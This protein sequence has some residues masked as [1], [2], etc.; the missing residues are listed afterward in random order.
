[1][2]SDLKSDLVMTPFQRRPTVHLMGNPAVSFLYK[3][4]LLFPF[5]C[6]EEVFVS[7]GGC[8]VRMVRPFTMLATEEPDSAG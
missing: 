4:E 7:G 1:M 2:A 8:A 6:R 5:V 3:N